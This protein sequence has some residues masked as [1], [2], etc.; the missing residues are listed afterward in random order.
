G[1]DPHDL[2]RHRSRARATRRPRRAP[3]SRDRAPARRGHPGRTRDVDTA[4]PLRPAVAGAE[5]RPAGGT[6]PYPAGRVAVGG[7]AP[8]AHDRWCGMTRKI[9]SA[10]PVLASAA[11]TSLCLVTGAV[12]PSTGAAAAAVPAAPARAEVPSASGTAAGL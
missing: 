12:A 3:G 6:D 1:T 8:P 4:Q 2:P 7:R 9:L 10:R 5:V 11:V